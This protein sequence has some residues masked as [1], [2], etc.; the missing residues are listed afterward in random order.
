MSLSRE[1]PEKKKKVSKI[2][3]PHFITKVGIG[4][5]TRSSLWLND[6]NVK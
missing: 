6:I 4:N 1:P 2:K 5:K 3:I